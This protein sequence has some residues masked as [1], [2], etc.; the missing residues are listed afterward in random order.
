MGLKRIIILA[1]IAFVVFYAVRSP[2]SAA[3]T[4]RVAA[5]TS[6]A[7]LKDLAESLARFFDAL[8]RK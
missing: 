4:F 2:D 3:L 6:R 8:I 1:A 7:G 5:K